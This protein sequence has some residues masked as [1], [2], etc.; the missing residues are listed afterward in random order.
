M[1]KQFL[2]ENITSRKPAVTGRQ[3]KSVV[4]F[5]EF[6]HISGSRQDI[7]LRFSVL[8]FS[9]IHL[10]NSIVPDAEIMIFLF[11]LNNLKIGLLP[12]I[13]HNNIT[14]YFLYQFQGER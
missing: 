5:Y 12:E 7:H 3:K 4:Y 13:T 11:T 6:D 10:S 9:L 14:K 8:N 2:E 1:G